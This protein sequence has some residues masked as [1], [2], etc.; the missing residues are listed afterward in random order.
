MIVYTV[1]HRYSHDFDNLHAIFADE[2][3]AVKFAEELASSK[4]NLVQGFESPVTKFPKPGCNT[5]EIVC[6]HTWSAKK[7]VEAGDRWETVCVERN[8]VV[9]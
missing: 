2:A 1:W 7:L 5:S 3:K 8:E 6:L 4:F 9:P